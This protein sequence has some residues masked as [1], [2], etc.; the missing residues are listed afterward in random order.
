MQKYTLQ[1]SSNFY[2]KIIFILTLLISLSAFSEN[3]A[4]GSN[5]KEGEEKFN[6]IE[7]IMHHVSD[8]HEW[9]ICSIG[10][11][12]ITIPL[13]VI[14]YSST[15]GLVCFMSDNF[16][17]AAHKY[18]SYKIEHEHI[19]SEDTGETIFDISITKNVASMMMSALI[20][21]F[22]FCTVAGSLRRNA[23]QAPRGIQS[24]FEPLVIFVRDEIAKPYIGDKYAR[25]LPYLLTVFFFIW[26]NNLMGIIPSG[27][28]L[29]GNIAVTLTL[30]VFTLIITNV[31][32]NGAY[33]GHIFAP[34]VPV[35]I[36]PIMIPVEIISIFTKPFALMI[37]LFANI[38]AGHIIILSIVSMIFMFKNLL[39]AGAAIPFAI[40]MDVLEFGVAALQAYIFTLLSA[41]FIGQAVAEHEHHDDDHH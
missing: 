29:T 11:N 36:W 13:P 27:A 23:G 20:L 35:M 38:T 40:V 24:F 26:L 19:L 17:N 18:Q 41:L 30:S 34:P 15:K 12:H 8:S 9:H 32:A 33:W 7:V 37:R 21:I 25:F 1:M 16:H 6:A 10:E 3:V 31:S 5:E 28:N 14:L 22:I 4:E 39:V 2:R